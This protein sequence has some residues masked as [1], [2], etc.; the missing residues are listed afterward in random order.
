ML[1]FESSNNISNLIF[2]DASIIYYYTGFKVRLVLPNQDINK[3]T[4]YKNHKLLICS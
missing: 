1:R 2:K 3:M 4:I